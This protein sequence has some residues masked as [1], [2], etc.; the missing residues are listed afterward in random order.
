MT[1]TD[2]AHL[3]CLVLDFRLVNSVDASAAFILNRIRQYTRTQG[4]ELIISDTS[5]HIMKLLE[6]AGFP[7][8][9]QQDLHYVHSLDHAVEI[10]ENNLI[11]EADLEDTT[12]I[13]D[14]RKRL[15]NIFSSSADVEKFIGYLVMRDLKQG[16]YLLHKGDPSDHLYFVESG[17][18]SV[19]LLST[20]KK[21]TRVTTIQGGAIVGEIGL[22]LS[23]NR[24]ASVWASKSSRL[25]QLSRESF[26]KMEKE[27]PELASALHRWTAEILAGRLSDNIKT[28]EELL[29]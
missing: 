25:Y 13:I 18:L 8:C 28:L 2:K 20:S 19:E 22:Y 1:A 12:T 4:V 5:A 27:N 29:E 3:R 17:L 26:D 15:S 6:R 9:D 23:A 16:D 24:T 7:P 21:E 11:R 14:F 10:S